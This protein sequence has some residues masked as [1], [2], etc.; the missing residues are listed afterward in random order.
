M[1]KLVVWSS[2][3]LSSHLSADVTRRNKSGKKGE[4]VSDLG[5]V[6]QDVARAIIYGVPD[7]PRVPVNMCISSLMHPEI[8]S[9]HLQGLI[10]HGVQL[11]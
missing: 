8:R 2:L 7:V 4:R 3:S 10:P 1:S 6:Q 11:L 5:L 9:P